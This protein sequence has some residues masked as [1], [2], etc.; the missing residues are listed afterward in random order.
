MPM[1]WGPGISCQSHGISC[2]LKIV[3]SAPISV[4]H[5]NGLLSI[6]MVNFGWEPSEMLDTHKAS[7]GVVVVPLTVGVEACPFWSLKVPVPCHPYHIQCYSVCFS[8]NL[9]CSGGR[10]S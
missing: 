7:M 3:L 2:C 6:L 4:R 9:F 8:G 10:L 1:S 5:L